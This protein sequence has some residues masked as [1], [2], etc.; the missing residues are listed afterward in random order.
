M[1]KTVNKIYSL[2]LF[3]FYLKLSKW[4]FFEI[5]KFLIIIVTTPRKYVLSTNWRVL[6]KF[7]FVC[8]CVCV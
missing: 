1:Q 2:I 7:S 4:N 3:V 5:V 6:V 8:V